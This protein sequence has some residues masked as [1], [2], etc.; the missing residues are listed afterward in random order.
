[1]AAGQVRPIEHA[2]RDAHRDGVEKLLRR[3]IGPVGET[4][5]IGENVGGAGGENTKRN[6]GADYAVDRFVD[7]AVAAGGEDE[8]AARVDR[9]AGKIAGR[10]R[11]GGG[12]ELYVR[13]GF[14][15]GTNGGIETR[16]SGPFQ[17]ARKRIVNDS[18]T[19]GL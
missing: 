19:M 14:P 18:D 1:M 11:A 3:V 13:S 9:P 17:A 6:V 5:F 12:N 2:E 10:L 8:I 4:N 16:A 7:G 15:K